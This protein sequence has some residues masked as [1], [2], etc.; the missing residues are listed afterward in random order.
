M[1]GGT[2]INGSDV[3]LDTEII[4]LQT[5]CDDSIEGLDGRAV[6]GAMTRLQSLVDHAGV[7]PLL[8]DLAKREGPNTLRNVATVGGTIAAADP[9]SELLAGLLVH[10]ASLTIA[11]Q[12]G[13]LDMAL[14][15]LVADL[16]LLREGII[17]SISV[18]G[19]GVTASARTGRTPADTSIVAAMGRKVDGRLLLALT[20]VASTP[21]LVAPNGIGAL[22][23]PADFRGSSEYRRN[24]AEIL[25]RRVLGQL[26]GAE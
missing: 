7:P 9:E 17:T 4:D 10:E 19:G 14:A 3:D 25:T 11:R 15:D 16:S 5:A 12:T 21:V 22:D 18:A 13:T 24:L 23:P 20:G 26:G 6:I 1:A 2:V 8:R